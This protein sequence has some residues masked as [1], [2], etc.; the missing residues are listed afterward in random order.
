MIWRDI[1]VSLRDLTL[2][3]H[4]A[5]HRIDDAGKLKEQAIAGSFDYAAAVLL[6]LGIGHLAPKYLQPRE[7]ALLVG[8]ISRL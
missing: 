7:R 1:G 8:T 2:H 3:F 6:D 4:G 5:A